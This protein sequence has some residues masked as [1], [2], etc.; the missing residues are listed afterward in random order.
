MNMKKKL[1]LIFKKIGYIL[2]KIKKYI[3]NRFGPGFYINKGKEFL[4]SKKC[5]QAIQILEKGIRKYPK[6][7][8]IVLELNKILIRRKEWKKVIE[9]GNDFLEFNNYKIPSQI[10]IDLSSA[11]LKTNHLIE[12]EKILLK[13]IREKNFKTKSF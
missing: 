4:K 11:Y 12:A 10:L 6:N 2:P 7:H 9:I 13:A 5:S 1:K 8:V 3:Y